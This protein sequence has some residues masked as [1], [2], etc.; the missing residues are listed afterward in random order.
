M[1]RE[2]GTDILSFI[3]NIIYEK[4]QVE[5]YGVYFTISKIFRLTGTGEIDFGGGEYRESKR[6]EI[7]PVKRKGEDKYGWWEL[8]QGEYLIEFNEKLQ[9]VLPDAKLVILQPSEKITQNGAFHTTKVIDKKGK[10]KAT[11]YVGKNGINIKENARVSE[12]IVLD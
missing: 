5:D 4:K 6:E 2:K 10:V 7:K 12:L 3:S 1:K 11:L 9:E 8:S